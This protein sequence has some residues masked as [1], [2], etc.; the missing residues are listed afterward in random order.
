[1]QR[2]DCT[3]LTLFQGDFP[4]NPFPLPGSSEARQTTVISGRKCAESCASC[5]PLGYAVRM[6]LTSSIWHS[7]RCL[8][9]WRKKAT[10][11]QHY[12]YRLAVSVPGTGVKELQYWHTETEWRAARERQFARLI[13][14]LTASAARGAASDRY[15][16]GGKYRHQI[17]ELVEPTPWGI[18][19]RLNPEWAEWLMG[20]PIGWTGLDA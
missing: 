19:G 11:Q 8:L 12:I 18:C 17:E 10:K 7:T 9:T 2:Q 1:M 6:C 16:G 14:T 13:P 3:Q 20:Y 15:F 4:A 5:T